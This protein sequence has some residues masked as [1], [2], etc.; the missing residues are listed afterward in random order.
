MARA[1]FFFLLPGLLFLRVFFVSLCYDV[2]C[3]Y[4]ATCNARHDRMKWGMMASC[5]ARLVPVM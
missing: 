5:S 1:L 3:M 2:G 4:I